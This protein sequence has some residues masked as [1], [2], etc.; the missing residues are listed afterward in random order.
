MERKIGEIFKY[1]NDWYQCVEAPLDE[2]SCNG[3]YGCKINGGE[4][5][6][7]ARNDGKFVIFKKLKKVGEPYFNEQLGCFFQQYEL[8]YNDLVYIAGDV[9]YAKLGNTILLEN[10]QL[11]EDMEEND[12]NL[13]HFDLEA[14]KQ[15]K[16]VCTRDGQKVRIICFDLKSE[17]PIVAA[18][19]QNDGTERLAQ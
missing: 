5:N 8:Y 11:Q 19:S 9:K 14:S 17:Q 15:G 2:H 18:I 12:L 13:K 4:C 1:N 3:C 10:K 6:G 16:T 7:N